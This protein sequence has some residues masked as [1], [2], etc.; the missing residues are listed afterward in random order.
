MPRRWSRVP[1]G[2]AAAGLNK[3]LIRPVSNPD[4]PVAG[5]CHRA[6]TP[7][8]V[9]RAGRGRNAMDRDDLLVLCERFASR[10]TGVSVGRVTVEALGGV[11]PVPEI[12]RS[13]RG[14]EISESEKN[15]LLT[16]VCDPEEEADLCAESACVRDPFADARDT[17]C[18]EDD[19]PAGPSR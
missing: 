15:A 7:E 9:E 19:E 6:A 18:D 12:M 5:W 11:D 8:R 3:L 4:T 16:L 2:P 1:K 14:A 17:G 10:R 13:F